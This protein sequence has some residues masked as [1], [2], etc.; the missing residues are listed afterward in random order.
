MDLIAVSQA[1]RD[2][3]DVLPEDMDLADLSGINARRRKELR[4]LIREAILRL[5]VVAAGLD[6]VQ[7]PRVVFDPSNPEVVGKLIGESVLEQPRMPLGSVSRFYGSGVDSI[8]YNGDFPAY[9]AIVGTDTPIYVGKADP[10]ILDARTPL[11][12]GEKLYGRLNG[13]HARSVRQAEDRGRVADVGQYIKI[14]EFECRCL[15]V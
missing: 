1:L 6:P 4:V 10:A 12:Q 11:E 15:V 8:Y 5:D 3:L 2:L 13:D 7:M 9:L 14:A